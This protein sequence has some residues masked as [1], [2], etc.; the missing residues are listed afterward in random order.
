RLALTPAANLPASAPALVG[1][2]L[3]L[4]TGLLALTWSGDPGANQVVVSYDAD[5]YRPGFRG[6][7]DATETA[8]HILASPA[9]VGSPLPAAATDTHFGEREL[10]KLAFADAS[11]SV[12]ENRSGSAPSLPVTVGGV[13]Y[14]AQDLGAL[15][16]VAVPNLLP[17]G[18]TDFGSDFQ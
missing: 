11:T 1:G 8:A 18:A 10:V 6:A 2:F 14:S 9:S 16:A 5:P 7:G 15:P 3:N 4:A 17:A 13:T 12:Q